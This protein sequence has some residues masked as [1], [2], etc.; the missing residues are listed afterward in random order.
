MVSSI[1]IKATHNSMTKSDQ[2]ENNPLHNWFYIDIFHD[3]AAA[4]LHVIIMYL[5][6]QQDPRGRDWE[7][8]FRPCCQCW[9][10]TRKEIVNF[11]FKNQFY[12][13]DSFINRQSP[14]FSHFTKTLLSP[15]MRILQLLSFHFGHRLHSPWQFD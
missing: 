10:S 13:G 2:R 7:R 5:V 3:A 12:A 1:K 14:K 9:S 15:K 8:C 11:T 6:L 4:L